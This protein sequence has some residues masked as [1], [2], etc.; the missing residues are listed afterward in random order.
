MPPHRPLLA[1]PMGTFP[2]PGTATT[3]SG[4]F[5][6]E[7]TNRSPFALGRNPGTAGTS[8]VY[9]RRFAVL[10]KQLLSTP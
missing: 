2:M 3:M 7:F 6:H 8:G 1:L 9:P 10:L 5:G 4:S